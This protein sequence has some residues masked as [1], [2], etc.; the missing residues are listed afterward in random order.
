MGGYPLRTVGLNIVGLKRRG[1]TMAQVKPLKAAF[2][3]LFGADL[4]TSQALERVE[5]EVEQTPEVAHVVQFVR[6]SE[7]GIVK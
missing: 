3:I 1:F 2:R 6:E 7:R 4:N 5:A